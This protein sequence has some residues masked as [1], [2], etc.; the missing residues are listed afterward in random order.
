MTTVPIVPQGPG[1]PPVPWLVKSDIAAALTGACFKY[2]FPSFPNS[3]GMVAAEALVISILARVI[4][5][6]MN[7]SV[8]SLNDAQKS[9]ILVGL[10]GALGAAVKKHDPLQGGLGFMAIDCLANEFMSILS[11]SEGSVFNR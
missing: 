3:V 4:P 1:L 2:V 8:A 7:I 6:N 11:F 9:E 5:A 10:L